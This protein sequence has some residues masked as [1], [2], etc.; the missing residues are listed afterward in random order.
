MYAYGAIIH[1]IIGATQLR[2]LY[3]EAKCSTRWHIPSRFNNSITHMTI[4]NNNGPWQWPSSLISLESIRCKNVSLATLPRT[5]T[6]LLL[7]HTRVNQ[8]DQHDKEEID[9]NKQLLLL[10]DHVT[11]LHYE[12]PRGDRS[13]INIINKQWPPHHHG[14]RASSSSLV[15]VTLELQH[16]SDTI[17]VKEFFHWLA[18]SFC[19]E[20]RRFT[21]IMTSLPSLSSSLTNTS[22]ST[23]SSNTGR[24]CWPQLTHLSFTF[25]HIVISR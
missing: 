16:S 2:S 6:E 4:V 18:I 24:V 5:C 21:D 3:I 1:I 8:D 13:L 19:Y 14:T 9:H 15:V 23:S 7:T 10:F 20:Y 17:G 22:T 25:E 11:H 12:P